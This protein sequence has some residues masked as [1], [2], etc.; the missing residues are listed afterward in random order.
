MSELNPEPRRIAEERR[1]ATS[2]ERYHKHLWD[3]RVTSWEHEGARGLE[4]VVE[5]VLKHADAQFDT[6]AVD[7]GCGTGE[8]SLPLAEIAAQVTAVDLSPAMVERLSEKAALAGLENLVGIV[9]SIEDFGIPAESVDLIVSNYA[10]HHLSHSGKKAAVAA[11]ASWLKPGGRLV[12]G[13]MMFGRGLTAHDR[14]VIRTKVGT[15]IRRGPGGWWRLVKN[16]GRFTFRLRERPATME[17]WVQYF[18]QA[19]FRDVTVVPVVS[20]AAVV[21]GTRR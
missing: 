3:Q 1:S 7:L 16:V 17:M 2:S 13:D 18:E 9:S 14:T 20:E 11:A 8:V 6:V 15:L 4:Q 10:L 5:V 19:G 21:A 12:V